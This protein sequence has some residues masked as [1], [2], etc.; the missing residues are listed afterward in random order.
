MQAL[1]DPDSTQQI[2]LAGMMLRLRLAQFPTGN[3]FLHVGVITR[4]P[5][6][7]PGAQEIETAVTDVRIARRLRL[8]VD[9]EHRRRRAHPLI[10]G[11]LGGRIQHL[12]IGAQDGTL[13]RCRVNGLSGICHIMHGGDDDA[14]CHL[15]CRVSAEPIRHDVDS[16]RKDAAA[17]LVR[18]AHAS[19][20]RCA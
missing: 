18:C 20:V 16:G 19:D 4:N 1:L 11:V 12:L 14:A 13:E 9:M 15:A 5:A 10:G 6:Q 2:V 8:L 7:R 3:Q 17:V